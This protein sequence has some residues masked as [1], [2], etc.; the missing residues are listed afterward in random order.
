MAFTRLSAI[1]GGGVELSQAVF[2]TKGLDPDI[3]IN[4]SRFLQS[5]LIETD[6]STFDVNVFTHKVGVNFALE[7]AGFGGDNV[8][9]LAFG[10][11]LFVAVGTN[12]KLA[13]SPDGITWTQQTSSFGAT[14]INRIRQLNDLFVICGNSAKL[15]ESNDGINWDLSTTVATQTLRGLAFNGSASMSA[16]NSSEVMTFDVLQFAG[17]Q[18]PYSE[19]GENQYIRIS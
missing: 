16:G 8:F 14:G 3:T 11:G 6:S 15:A 4:G 12:G 5:G 1:A 9:N 7:D 18:T 13:T 17:S 19:N 2:L 10:V